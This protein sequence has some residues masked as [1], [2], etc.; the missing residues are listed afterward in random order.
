M[1]S[2]N[3]NS[4]NS[5]MDITHV[6]NNLRKLSGLSETLGITNFIISKQAI[7]AIK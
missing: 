3:K 4:S 5:D 2:S 1:S 6:I 7:I